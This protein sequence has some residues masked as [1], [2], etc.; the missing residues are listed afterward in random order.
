MGYAARPNEL[1]QGQIKAG[2]TGYFA[3]PPGLEH[4]MRSKFA[5]IAMG[6]NV[7]KSTREVNA[8]VQIPKTSHL[9]LTNCQ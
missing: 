1:V 8:P 7:G 4:E 9:R 5:L 3:G 2:L 6:W